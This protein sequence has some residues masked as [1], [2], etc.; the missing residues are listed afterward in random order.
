MPRSGFAGSNDSSVF[1]FVRNLHTVLQSGCA[2]LHSH[3]Q[4]ER[5]PLTPHPL[6]HLLFIGILIIVILTGVRWH[7]IVV[8]IGISLIISNVKHLF[9]CLLAICMSYLK[10]CLFRSSSH[11]STGFLL[12]LLLSCISCFYILEIRLLSVA[13]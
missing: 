7:I 4:Y 2:S 12:L 10:K 8:L 11:F 5:V 6:Q 13:L 1:S 3:Q 9:L